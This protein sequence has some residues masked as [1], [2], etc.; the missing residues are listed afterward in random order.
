MSSQE[1]KVSQSLSGK[2]ASGF[3]VFYT[4]LPP[5]HPLAI[6]ESWD[7][8]LV[9]S[10]VRKDTIELVQAGY[11]VYVIAAGPEIPREIIAEKMRAK[12]VE[13]HITGIGMGVRASKNPTVIH[14]LEDLVQFFRHETP[15]AQQVFN[16]G[17]GSCLESVEYRLGKNNNSNNQPGQLLGYEEL[18]DG[19]RGEPLEFI[20]PK[21]I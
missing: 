19:Q 5:Y 16:S 13:W 4:G 17:P 15:G 2:A 3:N 8:A 7:P 20:P 12:G 18:F 9:D 21:D 1:T 10:G 6:A 14:Y 11:N